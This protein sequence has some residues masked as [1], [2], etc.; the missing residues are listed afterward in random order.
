VVILVV[1]IS[2][3]EKLGMGSLRWSFFIG[4]IL[5]LAA[6]STESNYESEVQTNGRLSEEDCHFVNDDMNR[7]DSFHAAVKKDEWKA[8][9]TAIVDKVLKVSKH[10]K[11]LSIAS[12]I[13]YGRTGTRNSGSAIFMYTMRIMNS[14]SDHIYS[15]RFKIYSTASKD[16]STE[17]YHLAKSVGTVSAE[18]V[19]SSDSAV[20]RIN[21][22]NVKKNISNVPSNLF[23]DYC[24]GNPH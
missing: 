14:A 21:T 5:P 13:D 15:G 19:D 1:S 18:I 24:E 16:G 12:D 8:G 7:A 22:T 23:W 11:D 6:C 10:H 4:L 20:I 17:I 2:Q 3:G 9:V